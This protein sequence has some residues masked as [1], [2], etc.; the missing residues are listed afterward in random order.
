M[1]QLQRTTPIRYAIAQAGRYRQGASLLSY[2]LIVGLISV[3]ALAAVTSVG[4]NTDQLFGEVGTSLNDV[5]SS[6]SGVQSQPT[7]IVEATCADPVGDSLPI[8][9]ACDDGSVFAGVTPDGNV[10]MFT[11]RCDAGQKWDGSTCTGSRHYI[12]F[13]NWTESG[14]NVVVSSYSFPA[15]PPGQSNVDGETATAYH[16]GRT[17]GGAPYPAAQHCHDLVENSQSDWYL[18]ARDE[19]NALMANRASIGNIDDSQFVSTSVG[20]FDAGAGRFGFDNRN[21]YWSSSE[22]PNFTDVAWNV[23]F[24]PAVF[25]NNTAK[26]QGFFVRCIRK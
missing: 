21:A 8:G 20:G 12:N 3:V 24:T 11:T 4:S 2:G 1:K 6:Q 16:A 26:R 13:G 14:G 17:D 23:M 9:S 18:P 5:I 19:L 7:P 25:N 10:A 22:D 15:D